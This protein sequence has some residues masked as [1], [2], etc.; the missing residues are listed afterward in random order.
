[1]EKI[2]ISILLT[3]ETWVA[4]DT[5]VRNA[6]IIQNFIMLIG[7]LLLFQNLTLYISL[8]I[9]YQTILSLFEKKERTNFVFINL[10]GPIDSTILIDI[11]TIQT[12]INSKCNNS[13][14]FIE[15]R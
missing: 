9:L 6:K 10:L 5:V 8:Y 15:D 4:N 13:A 14:Y 3:L 12:N 1:M 11:C 7:R 2:L